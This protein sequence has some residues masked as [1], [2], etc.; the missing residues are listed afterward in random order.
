MSALHYSKG[1]MRLYKLL[2][3]KHKNYDES[4]EVNI[5]FPTKALG[6]KENKSE[7]AT[8]EKGGATN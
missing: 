1:R 7:S 2:K 5:K 8:T 3:I 4:L 6:K